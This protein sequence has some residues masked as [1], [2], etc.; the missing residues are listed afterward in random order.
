MEI[1]KIVI[2][3]KIKKLINVALA[4]TDINK[5]KVKY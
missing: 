5:F 4:T 3:N 2:W 1:I